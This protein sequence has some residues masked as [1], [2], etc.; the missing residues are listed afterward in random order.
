L[1]RKLRRVRALEL[2]KRKKEAQVVLKEVKSQRRIT[3]LL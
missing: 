2:F 3:G 1:R